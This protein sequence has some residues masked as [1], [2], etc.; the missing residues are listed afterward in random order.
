MRNREGQV[1]CVVQHLTPTI[2]DLLADRPQVLLKG[3]LYLKFF[4]GALSVAEYPRT[5]VLF[6]EVKDDFLR[7]TDLDNQ[8]SAPTLQLILEI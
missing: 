1:C 3:V 5:L 8:I 7:F 6:G 4:V 2:P